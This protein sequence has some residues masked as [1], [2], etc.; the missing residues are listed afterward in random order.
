MPY[1]Y[2][3]LSEAVVR[4]R[5]TRASL[6]SGDQ[7]GVVGKTGLALTSIERPVPVRWSTTD[8]VAFSSSLY[9]ASVPSARVPSWSS[10]YSKYRE[11]W[12]NRSVPGCRMKSFLP[13]S[14]VYETSF[15]GSDDRSST[16]TEVSGSRI[17][18]VSAA[19]PGVV[20]VAA[21]GASAP[22]ETL[23]TTK[24][25]AATSTA[26]ATAAPATIHPVPRPFSPGEAGGGCGPAAAALPCHSNPAAGPPA[27]EKPPLPGAP[28]GP[29]GEARR[30]PPPG[31]G[32]DGP[33][34]PEG[35]APTRS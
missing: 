20:R 9:C 28:A 12:R 14:I 10:T 16:V 8:T 24:T 30:A 33:P 26:V 21:G 17:V 19:G 34:G 27:P 4:Y 1:P 5:V 3:T 15:T 23:F 11:S 32:P 22:A 29:L 25:P 7:R 6:P 2:G 18:L 31:I 35:N 13:P